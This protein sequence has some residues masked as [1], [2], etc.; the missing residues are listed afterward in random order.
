VD[1][2]LICSITSMSSPLRLVRV[3]CCLASLRKTIAPDVTMPSGSSII[4]G[5]SSGSMVIIPSPSFSGTYD[6]PVDP[7]TMVEPVILATDP[8]RLMSS[9]VCNFCRT[10][11]LMLRAPRPLMVLLPGFITASMPGKPDKALSIS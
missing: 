3:I 11:V 5:C 9:G 2:F 7:G 1:F 8:G 6:S 4:R 10:K